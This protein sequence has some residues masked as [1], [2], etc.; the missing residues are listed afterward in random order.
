M[1]N[2]TA[3]VLRWAALMRGGKFIARSMTKLVDAGSFVL[4]AFG[5]HRKTA[6]IMPNKS[7]EWLIIVALE[8]MKIARTNP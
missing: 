3:G 5:V 7:S 1:Q 8:K 6:V 2:R 4:P